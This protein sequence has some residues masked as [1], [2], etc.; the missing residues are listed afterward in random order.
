VQFGIFDAE[1]ILTNWF[2]RLGYHTLSFIFAALVLIYGGA[3]I[4]PAP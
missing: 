1:P 2:Y 3:A 4:F